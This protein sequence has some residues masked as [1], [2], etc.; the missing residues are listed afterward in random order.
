MQLICSELFN[1]DDVKTRGFADVAG[2]TM[3]RYKNRRKRYLTTKRIDSQRENN[4]EE[5][6]HKLRKRRPHSGVSSRDIPKNESLCLSNLPPAWRS[7]HAS[8]MSLKETRIKCDEQQR[9]D[10]EMASTTHLPPPRKMTDTSNPVYFL[11]VGKAGGTSIDNMVGNILK[12]MDKA[13]IGDQHF[14]WSFIQR[15]ISIHQQRYLRGIRISS[16]GN[17]IGKVADVITFLRD[18]VSRAVS[19]FYFSKKL[20]W[21]KRNNA[22]FLS[23]TFEE[24]L[25]DP[26]KTWTQPI[27]DGESGADFLAGIFPTSAGLWVE[28]D[29]METD[30]KIYLRKNKTAACLFA[31]QRLENTTWFGLME[32]I[33]RSMKLLQVTLGLD[34]TPILPRVNGNSGNP[35]PTMLT[36]SKIK[37]Y[38]PKDLWLYEYAKRLF[39]ARWKYF[40]GI[41]CLYVSPELPPL[42]T[43]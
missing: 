26:N 16:N 14:D 2:V 3:T 6:T 24:Y 20:P 36:V 40:M 9:N 39:E 32:D 11:H 30:M 29:R 38:I 23:Q 41:D 8:M 27:S 35:Q 37:K 33:D 43:F 5:H 1:G 4:I 18:P 21:A 13:Y 42:P 19:Q 17:D 25:E 34:F 15:H 12:C 28:T 7:N 10:Y 31:A 22:T